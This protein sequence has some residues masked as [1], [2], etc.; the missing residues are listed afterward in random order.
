MRTRTAVKLAIAGAI[1][2]LL[3]GFIVRTALK[4]AATAMLSMLFLIVLVVLVAWVAVKW[5]R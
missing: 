5:K 4:L 2:V 3:A 1:A